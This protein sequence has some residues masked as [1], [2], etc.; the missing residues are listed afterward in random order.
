MSTAMKVC[1]RARKS[2]EMDET[3][4]IDYY[5]TCREDSNLEDSRIIPVIPV[6]GMSGSSC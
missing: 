5:I 6:G 2:L 1:T 3:L 4:K